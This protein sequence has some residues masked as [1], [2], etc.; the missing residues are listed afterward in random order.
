M[1]RSSARVLRLAFTSS[2]AALAAGCADDVW[3]SGSRLRADL[4]E[5]DGIR[6]LIDFVDEETG[7]HCLGEACGTFVTLQTS[8]R[9]A[10]IAE[11]EME[12]LEGDDGSWQYVRLHDTTHD[13]PCSMQPFD[14]EV[15]CVAGK[16]FATAEKTCAEE[17]IECGM[18]DTSCVDGA[19]AVVT[20]AG[21]AVIF[22]IG[23]EEDAPMDASCVVKSC[24]EGC[25]HR[26]LT[27]VEPASLPRV[28]EKNLG[29]GKWLLPSYTSQ[30]GAWS[31]PIETGTLLDTT[32]NT[33]CRLARGADGAVACN[34][35]G[36]P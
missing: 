35:I 22:E 23:G 31:V 10:E 27:K 9:T 32:T 26:A 24:V 11:L 15:R 12:G 28:Y 13:A 1:R 29:T 19:L 17:F 2:I 18:N 14:G 21:G 30:D 34:P 25:V 5:Q 7:Q 20:V 4:Y 6:T 36:A 3:E 33:K 8:Y 16:V